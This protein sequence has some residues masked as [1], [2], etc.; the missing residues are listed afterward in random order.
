ML[1]EAAELA[2]AMVDPVLAVHLIEAAMLAFE[3]EQEE[4]TYT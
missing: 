3:E 1:V 2:Y 4:I